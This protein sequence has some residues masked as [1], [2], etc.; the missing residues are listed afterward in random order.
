MSHG[1]DDPALVIRNEAEGEAKIAAEDDWESALDGGEGYQGARGVVA[2]W[3]RPT[4]GYST[5][6]EESEGP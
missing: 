4:G 6:Q 3:A 5:L 2:Y 1:K